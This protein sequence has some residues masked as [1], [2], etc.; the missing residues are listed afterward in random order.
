MPEFESRAPAREGLPAT[1]RMRAEAAHYVDLLGSPSS[2]PRERTIPISSIDAPVFVDQPA[3]AP[4]VESIRRYGVLQPL[5]V[6]DRDGTYQLIA[7]RKRLA[8]AVSAGL[9][10]VPCI[11]HDVDDQK[12]EALARAAA[13][14]ATHDAALS[15][16]KAAPIAP[17]APASIPDATLHA[18]HDLSRALTTLAA[19]ADMLSG[20][21]SDMSRAVV[22][23]L[24]RAEAWRASTLLQAT[25]VLRQELK[26]AR[27][28]VP[29][30]GV[31]DR[32]VQG[33]AAERRVRPMTLDTHADLAR[34][35]CA[36]MDES[37]IGG[38]LAGA[39]LATLALF[40]GVPEAAIAVAVSAESGK[41]TFA[42]TQDIV[43]APPAWT[44]RAFDAGWTDRPGGVPAAVAV[45]AVRQTA[46]AHGGDA[47]VSA[48]A[49]GTRITLTI[50][51]GT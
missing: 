11:L 27:T 26:I 47:T 24:V 49:G 34:G 20:P 6:Q 46:A 43:A 30:A 40:D 7:G 17:I 14:C 25:R 39:V 1:Y 32:L 33:F 16:V 23:N 19:C 9:R 3:I 29:V 36:A 18:G 8:A 31:L 42:V 10:E 44:T 50:P 28:A 51:A 45:L 4:L 2:G 48:T 5:L 15:A 21:Q 12:A 38:A 35:A 41:V 37:M 22:A 13:I